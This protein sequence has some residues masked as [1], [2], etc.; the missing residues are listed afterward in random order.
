M[1]VLYSQCAG[2]DVHKDLIVACVR[3]VEG[4]QATHEIERFATTTRGLLELRAWLESHECT[5]VAMEA[6]GA[7]WKPVWHVLEDGF[8]LVLANA[9][10]I[11]NVPGRKSDV[12]DAAWISDLLAHG[13]I[14]ASFV[15]PQPIQELRDLTRTRRQLVREIA[16]HTQ[17][18][19]RVLE[20]ANVKLSSVVSNVV[21][22]SGRRIVRAMINGETDA[23]QLAELGHPRLR[24]S[25]KDLE[26][27]LRGSVR[28]HHRFLLRQHLRT[29]EQLEQTVGEF[30]ARIEALLVPFQ[31]EF[32]RLT[33][34]PGISTTAA[35]VL[36]AEI[37][38]DMTL[39]PSAKH[40][41]SWAGL[42]P[43]LDE[44]AGKHRST[45]LRKGA[46]WLKPVLVQ[47]A[48]AAAR[49]KGTYLQSQFLRIKARGGPKKAAVAVAASILTAVYHMLRDGQDYQDLGPA[50][51]SRRD[52][53][54]VAARLA[55][56]IRELGYEVD[57]RAAAA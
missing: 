35:Q 36:L 26:E 47:C 34:I 16:Q 14:R 37:G 28:E 4:R 2:L 51:F 30:E 31:V 52:S 12:S 8:E 7:Y 46:P 1:R 54:R 13:L 45:R 55:R 5:H 24:C 10:H 50:H 22:L 19:Q 18:L 38:S 44:S 3:R 9:A 21:G 56:R 29:I 42:C 48:W 11:R 41:L 20:D 39:F 15:P 6:T 57:I 53:D 27:A 33:T 49:T 25:K 43:R 32:A 23:E 40:L 17:R